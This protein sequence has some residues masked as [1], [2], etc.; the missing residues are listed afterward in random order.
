[1]AQATKQTWNAHD[2]LTSLTDAKGNTHKFEYDKAGRLIKETRPMG[3]AILYAY[4]AA[5]QLIQRT[6]AGGNTRSYA[7]DKAGRMVQEEHQLGGKE[8]DLMWQKS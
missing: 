8:T 4:D 3:G 6:D 1:M 5:G 2:Q 7:Y